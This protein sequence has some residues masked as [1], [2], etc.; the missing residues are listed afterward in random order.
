M[1]IM[2]NRKST[3]GVVEAALYNTNI[4]VEM[5]TGHGLFVRVD[6]QETMDINVR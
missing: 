1:C 6:E 4:N 2:L 3:F 5:I